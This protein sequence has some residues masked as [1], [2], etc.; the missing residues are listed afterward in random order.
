VARGTGPRLC[1]S[2]FTIDSL[3]FGI[4]LGHVGWRRDSRAQRVHGSQTRRELGTRLR[5]RASKPEAIQAFRG[6]PLRDSA[7]K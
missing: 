6:R 3:K 4:E 7:S 5:E 2:K 1:S